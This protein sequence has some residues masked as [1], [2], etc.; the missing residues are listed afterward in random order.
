MRQP[1][2]FSSAETA[3]IYERLLMPRIFIPW[4]MRL[5]GKAGLKA[6]DAV[7]DVATGPL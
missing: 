1:Q 6:G 2:R 3:G 5:L 7:L 4:G